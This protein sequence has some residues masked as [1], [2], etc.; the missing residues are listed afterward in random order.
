MAATGGSLLHRIRRLLGAPSSHSGRG[1][2]WLAGSV[3]LLLDRRH[4][5]RRGRPRPRRQRPAGAVAV[6]SGRCSGAAPLEVTLT[7]R[8]RRC[9]RSRSLVDAVRARARRSTIGR[10][11]CC[12]SR[13]SPGSRRLNEGRGAAA[14]SRARRPIARRNRP[15][16]VVA[17]TPVACVRTRAISM[18]QPLR[19][20]VGQLGWSNN[21][22][23]LE[24]SYSGTLRV[25]RRRHRRAPAVGRRLA[26]DFRRRVVRAALGRDPRAR[27][28]DRSPVLRQRL[29]SGRTSRRAASGCA[30]TCRSSCATPASARR[31]RVARFLKGGWR[32]RPSWGRSP[33][34]IAA[35]V[36]GVYYKELFKPGDA[37]AG[38]VPPG[39]D[40]GGA[41]DEERLR[42]G[43]R[44]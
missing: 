12:R 41:R 22:E 4:R 10:A 19:R 27:R 33:A 39:D 40:P 2:A 29:T 21:G 43:A 6:E 26:E 11:R 42:A 24:V 44:C 32:R 31:T 34:S 13:A 38:A 37:D 25:H 35:Y 17:A 30:R 18:S 8:A 16:P 7:C 15:S 14:G 1:P 20:S 36:K 28:A 5:P 23:K 9:G 3:A